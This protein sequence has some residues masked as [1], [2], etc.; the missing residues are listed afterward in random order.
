MSYDSVILVDEDDNMLGTMEKMAAHTRSKLHRA[1]SV[2][3]FNTK[4][5]LLLQRRAQ[6]KYHSA[7]KWSNTCC[8]HP[9]PGEKTKDAAKRRLKEEMGLECELDF[10][11]RF[12]YHAELDNGL[13]EHECDHVY[14]GTSSVAP[15]LNTQETDAF[16]Y[17]RLERIKTDLADNPEKYTVWFNVCFERVME[18]YNKIPEKK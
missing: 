15:E 11:F 8:S 18:Y 13:T 10:V 12:V 7:G 3:V 6:N 9:R 16:E 14:V 2:F 4:G 5:E 17:V 1:I